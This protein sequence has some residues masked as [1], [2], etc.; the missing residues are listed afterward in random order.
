MVLPSMASLASSLY[1]RKQLGI[2]D[3]MLLHILTAAG[4]FEWQFPFTVR[5]RKGIKRR[6]CGSGKN[7]WRRTSYDYV[8]DLSS[9]DDAY[10]GGS[11]CY[12]IFGQLGMII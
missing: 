1:V 6:V 2:Y 12:W 10:D 5:G 4:G 7:R 9:H 3:N 11:V 8:Q